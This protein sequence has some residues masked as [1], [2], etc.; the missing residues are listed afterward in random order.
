MQKYRS[1]HHSKWFL[2]KFRRKNSPLL[3]WAAPKMGTLSVR[4]G[5]QSLL[6]QQ[7]LLFPSTSTNSITSC[8][9]ERKRILINRK[10]P[11]AQQQRGVKA[12]F[13]DAKFMRNFKAAKDFGKLELAD[14]DRW[15]KDDATQRLKSG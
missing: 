4:L 10:L 13:P 9:S 6:K 8:A 7:F 12:W 3:S 2:C 15:I 1:Q 11:F 14:E 5:S